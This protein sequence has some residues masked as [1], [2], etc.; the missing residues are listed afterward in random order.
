M[1]FRKAPAR[2]FDGAPAIVKAHVLD[3]IKITPPAPLDFDVIFRPDP[4]AQEVTGLDFASNGAQGCHFSLKPW[5]ASAYLQRN[6]RKRVAWSDLP[7]ATQ[8][9]IVAYLE[10]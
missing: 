9:H 4:E 6:A 3:L 5:E 1:Q 10:S 2:F 7:V 8:A